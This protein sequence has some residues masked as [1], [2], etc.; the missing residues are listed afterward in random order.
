MAA[1]L[2]NNEVAARRRGQRADECNNQIVVDYV[3]GERALDNHAAGER[4]TAPSWWGCMCLCVLLA[5]SPLNE[6]FLFP[7]EPL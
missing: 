1:A 3:G 6:R 4:Q 2:D 5:K 7:P